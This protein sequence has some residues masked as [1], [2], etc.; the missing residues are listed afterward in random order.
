[1]V[2]TLIIFMNTVRENN[3]I[4]VITWQ[5]VLLVEETMVPGENQKPVNTH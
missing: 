2:F 5:S 3:N 1:M 4:S